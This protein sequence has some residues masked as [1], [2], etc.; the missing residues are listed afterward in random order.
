[1][2]LFTRLSLADL[3]DPNLDLGDES[4]ISFYACG[5]Q[6]EHANALAL[7]SRIESRIKDYYLCHFDET[8]AEFS[9][10]LLDLITKLPNLD[11]LW[12]KQTTINNSIAE[13]IVKAAPDLSRLTLGICS[14]QGRPV[15]ALL[16]GLKKLKYFELFQNTLDYNEIPV[17]ED[18]ADALLNS[19]SIESLRVCNNFIL[20]ENFKILLRVFSHLPLKNLDITHKEGI[21]E[22]H[23]RL[24]MPLTSLESLSIHCS[25]SNGDKVKDSTVESIISLIETTSNLKELDFFELTEN[26]IENVSLRENL[27]H[28]LR[29]KNI[30]FERPLSSAPTK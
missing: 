25:A 2:A 28:Q 23:I 6:L 20:N 24:L 16:G 14:F 7:T 5:Q 17:L 12:L 10:Q 9:S 15:S 21:D 8:T 1:M 19:K 27:V 22:E 3:T 13:K 29:T 18:I 4:P 26:R 11:L 30:K